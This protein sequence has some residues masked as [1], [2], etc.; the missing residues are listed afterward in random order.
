MRILTFDIGGTNIK[1]ALCNEAFELSEMHTIPT[2]ASKGGQHIIEKVIAIIES[3]EQLDRIA[4]STAG[5]VDSTNGIVVYSTGSIPYYTGMMV[6]KII[7]NKTGILTYV[8]ND[9]NAAAL[10]E[11]HF[12]AGKGKS[13]FLC[14]TYGSGIGGA[15]Y[16]NHKL[17][18]GAASSAAEFGHMI[19]HANGRECTCGGKGCYECYASTKA[20]IEAVNQVADEPLDGFTIFEKQ[21]ITN[22]K[23][24]AIVDDWIDEMILGL[25]NLIYI[26][27]PSL[28]ILGGGVLN[29]D[30]I[31]DL[32]DR[33]IYKQLMENYTNVNIVRSRLGN[34][35]ALLGAA[36]EASQL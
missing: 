18:K 25:I 14:L 7:E 10:G 30:Y 24:R 6:K 32:I 8:E 29:E 17:Y 21:N 3:Y 15:I 2:E 33:K 23:I 31:I 16:L 12:G 13:D 11:A 36:H 1:Y 4:V 20:L 22:P 9:V 5:Q 26:F 34:T 27:N 28:V 35:A 19:T